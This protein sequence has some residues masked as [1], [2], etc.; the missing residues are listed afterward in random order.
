[1]RSCGSDAFGLEDIHKPGVSASNVGY[2][3]VACRFL[4]QKIHEHFPENCPA[5]SKANK[6][7]N[8]GRRLEPMAHFFLVFTSN[9]DDAAH[10]F[11]AVST[12][13]RNHLLAILK[14]I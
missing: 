10:C 2:G 11:P 5:N 3:L 13:R 9:E 12:S 7:G 1:V 14:V 4:C 6:S 8:L